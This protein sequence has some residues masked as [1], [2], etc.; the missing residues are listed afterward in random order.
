[1]RL[2]LLIVAVLGSVLS[3]L[4][5]DSLIINLSVFQYIGIEFLITVMHQLYNYAK[6]ME[7]NKYKS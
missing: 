7:V 1:M 6:T 2:R 3:F 4:F 5:I